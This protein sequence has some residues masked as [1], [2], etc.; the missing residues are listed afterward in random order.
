M[1]RDK[2]I[3]PVEATIIRKLPEEIFSH[4]PCTEDYELLQKMDFLVD[5][6]I[7]EKHTRRE[8]VS[9]C[10]GGGTMRK[11]HG[12]YVLLV[13]GIFVLLLVGCGTTPQASGKQNEPG[14]Q[15]VQEQTEDTMY[16]TLYLSNE[17]DTLTQSEGQEQRNDE[18]NLNAV[19]V[20][21]IPKDELS[22]KRVVEAYNQLVIGGAY[23]SMLEINDVTEKDQAVWVD[24]D[25]GS[26]GAL[27]LEEG[28]EG[29]LF[30][31]LARS[32]YESIA[33]LEGIYFTMDGGKD[34]KVGHLW[35]VADRPF[36][37]G[38]V[39]TEG[40]EVSATPPAE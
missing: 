19:M 23:P 31:N 15:A 4:L 2:E 16:I 20:A 39:P 9:W 22:A 37:S 8:R 25:S 6:F 11:Q 40:G 14:Q 29:L 13:V 1:P 38:V 21:E 24:F 26:I 10:L 30:Y 7:K 33:D 34:F 3:F 17:L 32:I 18:E 35:F 12:I 28:T 5:I 27:Q 36:Y